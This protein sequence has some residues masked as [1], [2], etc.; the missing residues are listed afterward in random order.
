VKTA[1]VLFKAQKPLQNKIPIFRCDIWDWLGIIQC[2][3]INLTFWNWEAPLKILTENVT[4][5]MKLLHLLL[6]EQAFDYR[7]GRAPS[8]LKKFFKREAH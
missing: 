1:P 6:L 3:L 5:S 7:S 4:H 8:A 2:F